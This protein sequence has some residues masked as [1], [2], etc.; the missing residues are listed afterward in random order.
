MDKQ[1]KALHMSTLLKWAYRSKVSIYSQVEIDLNLIAAVGPYMVTLKFIGE[2]NAFLYGSQSS[3]ILGFDLA[4]R[5]S[6]RE[7]GMT[8]AVLLLWSLIGFY[9]D[10]G[11][12]PR[13]AVG[14]VSH[15]R[16]PMVGLDFYQHYALICSLT[17]HSLKGN[18]VKEN[19]LSIQYLNPSRCNAVGEDAVQKGKS[20]PLYSLGYHQEVH[21][22]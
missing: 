22:W 5:G 10:G 7:A 18:G 3:F 1:R 11:M 6:T 12:L 4:N 9:L 8:K 14:K 21:E 19:H 16:F 17:V 2:L 15:V 13:F 20:D